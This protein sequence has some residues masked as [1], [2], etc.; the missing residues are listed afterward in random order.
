[1]EQTY[2]NITFANDHWEPCRCDSD[3]NT[4]NYLPNSWY[5]CGC[6]AGNFTPINC[7]IVKPTPT[8]LLSN[9]EVLATTIPFSTTTVTNASITSVVAPAVTVTTLLC[10]S[11]TTGSALLCALQYMKKRKQELA[12]HSDSKDQQKY[13]A[14]S[15]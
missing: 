15:V 6:N 1:M 10:I 13:S 2:I 7:S 11:I 12:T 5:F 3:T 14:Y 9:T 8:M 4:N